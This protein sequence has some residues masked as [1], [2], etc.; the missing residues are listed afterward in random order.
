MHALFRYANRTSWN[1]KMPPYP[2]APMLAPSTVTPWAGVSSASPHVGDQVGAVVVR[3]HCGGGG[4]GGGGGGGGGGRSHI[5]TFPLLPLPHDRATSSCLG[6]ARLRVAGAL[7]CLFAVMS[8]DGRVCVHVRVR[9]VHWRAG[10][11]ASLL[12]RRRRR[13][14]QCQLTLDLD[15]FANWDSLMLAL[16]DRGIVCHLMILVGNKDVAWPA[17]G[18]EADDLCVGARGCACVRACVRAR[19]RRG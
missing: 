4:V 5:H 3:R 1:E 10:L 6:I 7:F 8:L 9:G 16:A 18:S 14:R 12:A 19:A 15:F 2:A 11:L 13:R 17:E